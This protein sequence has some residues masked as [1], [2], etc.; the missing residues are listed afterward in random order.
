MF[1]IRVSLQP[2]YSFHNEHVFFFARTEGLTEG[3]KLRAARFKSR[4]HVRC[5]NISQ[6]SSSASA[7]AGGSPRRSM[8][9]E[10]RVLDMLTSDRPDTCAVR[11]PSRGSS[12][13]PP[14]SFELEAAIDPATGLW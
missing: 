9:R 1:I 5:L 2:L 13:A 6:T 14:F 4:V 3:K 8:R 12:P 10:E 7:F 11:E